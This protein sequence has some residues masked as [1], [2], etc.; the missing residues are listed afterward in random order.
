MAAIITQAQ[1]IVADE[2]QAVSYT[3]I[4]VDTTTN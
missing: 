1:T 2:V 4:Q 3:E